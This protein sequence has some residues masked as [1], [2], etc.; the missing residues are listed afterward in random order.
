[1]NYQY[2]TFSDTATPVMLQDA[3]IFNGYKLRQIVHG[4]RR[5]DLSKNDYYYIPMKC[6][7]VSYRGAR[8]KALKPNASGN[9]NFIEKLDHG[10]WNFKPN[11]SDIYAAA[12]A[13]FN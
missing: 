2:V 13:R 4:G 5:I 8:A 11:A 10:H 12:M 6:L 7:L 9:L 1:M 3:G